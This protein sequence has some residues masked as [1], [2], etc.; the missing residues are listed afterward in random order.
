MLDPVNANDLISSTDE[1]ISMQ[2]NCGH[3][4]KASAPMTLRFASDEKTIFDKDELENANAAI[5][6][7]GEGTITDVKRRQL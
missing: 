6:L 3:L 1:G 5:F 7:R 2:V 4:E